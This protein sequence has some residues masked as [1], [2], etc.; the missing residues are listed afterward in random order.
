MWKNLLKQTKEVSQLIRKYPE[1][2]AKTKEFKKLFDLFQRTT[3]EDFNIKC[4]QSNI[5][6]PGRLQKVCFE[7]VPKEYSISLFFVPRRTLLPIHDHIDMHGISKVVTGSLFVN[8]YTIPS[9]EQRKKQYDFPFLKE[10]IDKNIEEKTSYKF[11]AMKTRLKLQEGH[12][13]VVYPVEGNLHSYFALQDYAF[14]YVL[15]PGYEYALF[16]GDKESKMNLYQEDDEYKQ[17][18]NK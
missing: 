16:E 10:N 14:F 12:C 7:E 8:S 2:A 13:G 11:D 5:F 3:K 9:A 6:F 17:V 18:L 4:G 1:A 15:L